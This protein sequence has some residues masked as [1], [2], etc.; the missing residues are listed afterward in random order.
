MGFHRKPD[1]LHRFVHLHRGHFLDDNPPGVPNPAGAQ[2]VN[3]A[4]AWLEVLGLSPQEG[5]A[6]DFVGLSRVGGWR[7]S[8]LDWER[9]TPRGVPTRGSLVVFSGPETGLPGHISVF[10]YG[11]VN[12]FTSFDQNWPEESPCHRQ[13]HDYGSVVGWARY[14]GDA[15]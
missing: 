12:E 4:N 13:G 9:N 3:L 15:P 10:L 5:N 11:D 7:G 8:R 2:C 14:L 1:V 6:V